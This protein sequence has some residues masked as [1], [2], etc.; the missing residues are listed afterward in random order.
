MSTRPSRPSAAPTSRRPVTGWSLGAALVMASLGALALTAPGCGGGSNE[1]RCDSTGCFD[2]DGYGCKPVTPPNIVPCSYA[3]DTVC[4]AGTVCTE[5]GCLSP[6]K[7]DGECAKGFVCKDSFCAPPTSTEVDPLVCGTS[8]DCEKLGAG[9]LCVDGKC[10]AAPTCEGA[11]C[12]CKY[13]SDCG[14]GRLCVDSKC[15]TAC[16]PGLPACATGFECSDKGYCV[17]GKPT[18]GAAAG[19]ATCPSGQKCVDGRCSAGC[20]SDDQCLGTDGKPDPTQRCV[21]GAC[22]PD[23]RTDTKCSGDT[24]CASGTQ[25]CVDGFCKYTCTSDDTCK[26]ID[27]RIGTCSPTEK[28]CRAATEVTAAC[29]S[30]ADCTDGKSCVDGQCK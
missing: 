8:K 11:S 7:T 24:Q 14:E 1:Y 2:C 18:C 6:C 23:E 26:A 5:L 3:G 13:S 12:T 21:G 9:A 10:V 28:I 29:T 4:S 30:K 22:I 15:E 27:S 17:E 20:A 25:K 16:G 19:G